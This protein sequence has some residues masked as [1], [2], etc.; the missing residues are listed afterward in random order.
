MDNSKTVY[1]IDKN[2]LN[3]FRG[4]S[5]MIIILSHLNPNLSIILR[6]ILPSGIAIFVFSTVYGLIMQYYR[7]GEGYLEGFI[8]KK[9][10]KKL[11]IPYFLVGILSTIITS[12]LDGNRFGCGPAI[13]IDWYVIFTL[14]IYICYFLFFKAIRSRHIRI[15]AAFISV[16]IYTILCLLLGLS[17]TWYQAVVLVLVSSLLVRKSFLTELFDNHRIPSL[18]VSFVLLHI[19]NLMTMDIINF[20]L[21]GTIG[22]EMVCVFTMVVMIL[23]MPMLNEVKYLSPYLRWVGLNSYIFYLLHP[24]LIRICEEWNLSKAISYIVIIAFISALIN[25]KQKLMQNCKRYIL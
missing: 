10:I 21:A 17:S 15:F 7:I 23:A 2:K 8:V 3:M 16:S 9:I 5:M 14:I 19:A 18:V 24:I 4:F 20:P 13:W 12:I 1:Y 11:F 25:L 22:A 6:T